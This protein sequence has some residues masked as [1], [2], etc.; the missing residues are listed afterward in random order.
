M[1]SETIKIIN[2]Y[3]KKF[4][5]DRDNLKLLEQQIEQKKNIFDRKNFTGHIVANAL[6]LNKDK[7]LTVFHNF[8]NMYLQPGGHV[9]ES[10]H[11]IV[12][13]ARREAEEETGLNTLKF[14]HRHEENG[15]PLFIESHLIP[16]NTKKNEQQHYHHDFMYIFQTEETNIDLQ[17]E[18]VS[19]F[20]RVSIE[21][22]V[23]QNP[24]SYIAKSL[25]KM[26][27]L[28]ILPNY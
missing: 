9:E 27:T 8:L 11:S 21:T 15:I 22:I 2:T 16:E 18:E 20:S 17:T 12:Q 25:K 10:D 24:D 13:A 28:N 1:Q 7:V 5:E 3:W 19:D 23:K 6:I 26:I 4:P 14:H